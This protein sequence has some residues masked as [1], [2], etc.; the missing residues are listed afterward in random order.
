MVKV[1]DI[2]DYMEKLAPSARKEDYDNVG[3]LAGFPEMGVIRVL[4]A[5]DITDAVIEE[6]RRMGA[7]VIVAHHPVIFG[8][9]SAV[10]DD[11]LT[12]RK[13]IKMIKYG[14]SAICMHTNLDV[15][16]GGVNEV[17]ARQVG[18][19][20][21]FVPYPAGV[22][23]EGRLYGLMRCGYLREEMDLADY[24]AFVKERLGAA[25][26][27]YVDAGRRVSKVAVIG[28]AGGSELQAA[29]N[30][31]CDTFITSDVKHNVFL[32]A[33]DLGVNLID[34]GH[35]PT[36]NG[37]TAELARLIREEFPRL[38]VKASRAGCQP[39]KFY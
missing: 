10:R 3:L 30:A 21:P 4:T 38:E 25:G 34:A 19:E 7:E 16:N 22:D 2:L 14:I 12:G 18:L 31:D 28:G 27:R 37:I 39:E 8:A 15:S 20:E 32:D 29:V 36:E 23:D 35:F 13:V 9:L 11:D 17:L 33:A 26:L 1:K 6:A 24:L 5:L